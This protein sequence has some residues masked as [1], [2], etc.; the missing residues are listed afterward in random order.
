MNSPCPP[1]IHIVL[2]TNHTLHGYLATSQITQQENRRC[3]P[4]RLT[5]LVHQMLN[6]SQS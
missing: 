5:Q 1:Q 4:D 6:R 3:I 2:C